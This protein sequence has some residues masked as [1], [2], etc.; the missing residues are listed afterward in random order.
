M[1]RIFALPG[2][3]S[4]LL[5]AVQQRDFPV[6]QAVTLLSAVTVVASNFAVDLLYGVLAPG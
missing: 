1:K 6:V 4:Y 2:M 3:G 5:S